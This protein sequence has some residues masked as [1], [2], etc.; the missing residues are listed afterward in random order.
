[1]GQ[2]TSLRAQFFQEALDIL[3]NAEEI[4]LHLEQHGTDQ[5]QVHSLFRLFHT[6][7]GNS[8]MVG[9]EEIN[10][11]THVLESEYDQVRTGKR[12]LDENLLQLTF[13]VI[14]TLTAVA[15]EGDSQD[16][17]EQMQTRAQELKNISASIAASAAETASR[18]GQGQNSASQASLSQAGRI[19]KS[20]Q[21]EIEAGFSVWKP[22]LHS[23]FKCEELAFRL[24]TAKDELPELLMDLGMEVIELRSLIEGEA[25]DTFAPLSRLSVYL[26]KLTATFAREQLAYNEISYE[27]LYVL[28]DDFKRSMWEHLYFTGALGYKKIVTMEELDRIEAEVRPGDRLWIIE[29]AF[30]SENSVR[31][32]DFFSRLIEIKRG[33]DVPLVFISPHSHYYRKAADLLSQA[34]G[35]YSQI[36]G[37][38]EEAVRMYILSEE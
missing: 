12:Q 3:S 10:A 13:E 18:Q 30:A 25:A 8:N 14:D 15:Q 5:E 24:P 38:L 33:L 37:T 23:F 31:R 4:V 26:E 7:K 32:S 29:L 2:D 11:L 1:M 22:V 27:L 16:Y 20:F 28:Y 19:E 21:N 9:E 34:L 35:S 36:A 17:I 6:L